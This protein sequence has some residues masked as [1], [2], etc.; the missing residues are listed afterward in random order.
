MRCVGWRPGLS[1]F[2]SYLL[3]STSA[4]PEDKEDVV[5]GHERVGDADY[6]QS[7]LREQE[8]RLATEMIRQRREDNRTEYHSNDEYCL[9]QIFKVFPITDQIPLNIHT[10]W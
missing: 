10:H 6:D 8:D 3:Q 5:V 7:P 1:S 2:R 9:R 4:E